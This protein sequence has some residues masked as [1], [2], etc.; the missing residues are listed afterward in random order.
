MG[1]KAST[2]ATEESLESSSGSGTSLSPGL[3]TKVIEDFQSTVLKEEW[4]KRQKYVLARGNERKIK[5]LQR[6]EQL[7]QQMT[8]FQEQNKKVQDQLDNKIDA[9]KAQF[10]DTMVE[11]QHDAKRLEDTYTSK[12]KKFQQEQPCTFER[13]NLTVCLNGSSKGTSPTQCDDLMEA[14]DRCVKRS[15][16]VH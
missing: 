2:S 13:A 16:V 14:M 5:E 15:L 10:V 4:E 12:N 11:M 3:Q 6:Q 7:E 9:T 1:N 8:A